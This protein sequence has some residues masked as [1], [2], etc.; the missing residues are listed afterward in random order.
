MAPN[1]VLLEAT[2]AE[3]RL[4]DDLKMGVRW[5]F[6]AGNHQLKF[7]DSLAGAVDRRSPASRISSAHPTSRSCSTP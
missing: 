5:F 3:V 4:K 7:T 1:Q 6:Q 2:I